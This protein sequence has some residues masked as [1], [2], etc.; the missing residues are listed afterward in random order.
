MLGI[1]GANRERGSERGG[2]EWV[3]VVVVVVGGGGRGE[4]GVLVKI[5]H[6]Y[7]F[8]VIHVHQKAI[9]KHGFI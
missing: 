4:N 3:V 9:P 5:E 1:G 7:L 2:G 8:K 6:K